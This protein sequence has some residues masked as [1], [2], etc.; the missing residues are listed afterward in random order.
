MVQL[1][2][3]AQLRWVPAGRDRSLATR[4]RVNH[5]RSSFQ[6]VGLGGEPVCPVHPG[7]IAGFPLPQYRADDP[8]GTLFFDAGE[9]DPVVFV[10][11]L[12]GNLTHFTYVA[13]PLVS[14]HRVLGLDLPGFGATR[15]PTGPISYAFMARSVLSLM[16]RRGVDRAVITG[17]SFGG[18]VALHLALHHPDRVRGVVLINPAGLHAF[19]LW[20]RLGSHL[21]LRPAITTPALLAGVFFILDNVCHLDRFEVDAFRRSATRL[22]G[23]YG[24]LRGLSSAA[25]ALR[26]DLVERSYLDQIEAL[27]QPAHLVWGDADGLLP[28]SDGEEAV[29][30]AP[31]A[32]LS[33]VPG[34]GHMPIFE[35]PEVVTDAI[36]DVLSRA[37][38]RDVLSDPT[39]RLPSLRTSRTAA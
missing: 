37:H 28:I 1:R 24:F 25:W 23:G 32:R 30:R 26:R 33:V 16:D 34:A 17:H 39:V 21:A 3:P 7:R 29:R 9:G 10:H 35:A 19:P 18:A 12:G 11:G 14:S 27:H 13:P 38:R 4:P 2:D 20:M 8:L 15:A 36:R 5:P 6:G 31:D 22:R